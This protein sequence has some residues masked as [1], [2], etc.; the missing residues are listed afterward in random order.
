VG[1]GAGWSARLA[2]AFARPNGVVRGRGSD[3]PGIANRPGRGAPAPP[4]VHEAR[5]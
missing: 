4:E 1:A 3:P 2:P 5:G